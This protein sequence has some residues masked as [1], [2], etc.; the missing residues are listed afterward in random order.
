[1]LRTLFQQFALNRIHWKLRYFEIG[2]MI[3]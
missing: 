1:M 3:T 2:A